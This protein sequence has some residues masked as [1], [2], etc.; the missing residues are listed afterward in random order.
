MPSIDPALLW[1]GTLNQR[2]VGPG[3]PQH[4]GLYDT[5]LRDGEQTV[6]VVFTPEQKLEIARLLDA[7][8]V[9]RIEAGFPRVSEDDR[10]A[11]ELVAAAGLDAEIW[12]FSRA[13]VDD[14]Q[15]IAD[16]GLR[17]TVIEAPVSDVK[18][19]ALD[20][21]ARQGARAIRDAVSH[22]RRQGIRVAFF[23][24]DGS[25]ADLLFLERAYRTAVDHGASEVVV[26]EHLGIAAPESAAFL[27][28]QVR[29]WLGDALPI[30]FHGHNDFGVATAAALAAVRAGASWIHG[31][32]DGMGERAGNADLAQVALALG[33]L[34][35]VHT[36][37]RLDRIR[38]V[39]STVRRL[40]GYTLEPWKAVVGRISSSA[41]PAPSRRSFICPRRSSRTRRRSSRHH[42]ASFSARRAVSRRSA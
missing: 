22:A 18:M 34:Y 35:N 6:G 26:V 15:A 13:L 4:V 12:G 14:V 24:V 30:D 28:G 16:L 29:S 39:S 37:L 10:R 8:G 25:R 42:A 5:N 33:A 32:V 41:R 17:C 23:G 2:A 36:N 11:V 1:T 27:V 40:A 21:C 38:A 31:T 19:R 9:D 20:V 3:M 7:L